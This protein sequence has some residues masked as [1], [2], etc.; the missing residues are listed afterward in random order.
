MAKGK[1]TTMKEIQGADEDL[2]KILPAVK[3]SS[4]TVYRPSQYTVPFECDGKQYVFN[5]LTKHCVEA[6]LPPSTK[7]GEGYDELILSR[8]LVPEGNDECDFY[9]S[10]I[11]LLRLYH[12]PKDF[13][14]YT[15]LPTLGCNARCVYC[16]EEGQKQV[17][18]TPGIVEQT[19]RFIQN[20]HQ[21]DEIA[22]SWFG[23]EPLLCPDIIDYICRR[24][25]ETGIEYTSTMVSNASLVTPEIVEKMAG[26]WRLKN[27]QVSM[28][29]AETDYIARKCYS[30]Y[31]DYY[32][33][34]MD[35]VKLISEAGINIQ[36]RCNV[37]FENWERIPLFIE[38]LKARIDNRDKV[39]LYFSPLYSLRASEDGITMVKQ[40][41]L[42]DE[43][44]R[45]AGF[46][47][48]VTIGVGRALRYSYCLAT[49]GGV[50]IHPDGGLYVC[51]QLPEK[52]KIGDV[53]NG[54][55]NEEAKREFSRM[56][57]VCGKCRA[58]AY[59]P[60]C[61]GFASCPVYDAN[62]REAHEI[63]TIGA[64]QNLVRYQ[65]TAIGESMPD[66]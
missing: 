12:N 50:V 31:R 57:R 14:G 47:K 61:T 7:A 64:L 27:I 1:K 20:T 29:G 2:L 48:P 46:K 52:S 56:D 40:I 22:L 9:T 24:L 45:K 63:A 62:C 66:C 18:M 42:A 33:S 44:V 5:T 26:D 38:D 17:K 36:I 37:D 19:V 16:Y 39:T 23:G 59:L 11:T 4:D 35:A 15:I 54:V 28:D 21:G 10:V 53:W 30:V 32:H 58:C 41:N 8:F 51:E 49:G 3:L 55:T 6:V 60:Y 25:R 43:M 65:E 34:T 13:R